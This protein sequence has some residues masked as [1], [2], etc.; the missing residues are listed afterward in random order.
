MKQKYLRI[1]YLVLFTLTVINLIYYAL[2]FYIPDNYFEISSNSN[3]INFFTYFISSVLALFSFFIGPWIIF[4]FIAM[5]LQTF[6][7][8]KLKDWQFFG[9][10]YIYLF[11][12][13]ALSHLMFPSLVGDGLENFI[14]V[15]APKWSIFILTLGFGYLV[16]NLTFNQDLPVLIKKIKDGY[17]TYQ[18]NAFIFLNWCREKYRYLKP[19]IFK[20]NTFRRNIA[21]KMVDYLRASQEKPVTINNQRPISPQTMVN[22]PIMP[23]PTTVKAEIQNSES[24]PQ[25]SNIKTVMTTENEEVMEESFDTNDISADE[26]QK[27]LERSQNIQVQ[28]EDFSTENLLSAISTKDQQKAVT[29]PD[30]VYFYS[31]IKAIEKKLAEFRIEAKVINISKGPVVDTFELEL[32]E[33]VKVSKIRDYSEDISLALSGIPIRMVH[34]MEGRSTIGIEV[35][36]SPR[37]L[38]FL[39]EVLQENIYT[40]SK[41][42]LPIAMG[43][44]SFGE[45]VVVDLEGM[46]HLLVAGTTGSGKSV[47][48]NTLLVSLV[49]KRSPKNLRLILIDPKQLELAHFQE[50]PHL[51][52]PIITDAAHALNALLWCVQEMERRYSIL[53]DFGVKNIEGYNIKLKNAELSQLAKINKYFEDEDSAGYELPYIVIIFD[54]YADFILSKYGKDIETN[55]SRLAAK[56]RASGMHIVLGTQRPSTQVVTGVIKSNFPTRISFKVSS[57][58]DS[59]VILDQMGAEKLLGKGDMLYRRGV[60]LKRYHSAFINEQEIEKLMHQFAKMPPQFNSKA[61]EFLENGPEEEELGG[62]ILENQDFNGGDELM[63]RAIQLVMEKRTASASMFQRHFNIGYPRAGKL[64]DDMERRGIIGPQQG[65]K[66]RKVLGISDS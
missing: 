25:E 63:E 6:K 58:I 62:G 66:P 17:K 7:K 64:I 36:R 33:G 5:T 10:P 19:Y 23:T 45:P 59:R 14:T 32:G 24:E 47:F 28:E 61:V 11:F 8:Q 21:A 27:T 2:A 30:D 37:E 9:S 54:E 16:Y 38:I 48:L 55:I 50:L 15:F 49:V 40:Q 60:D 65:S 12:F 3:Q 46:P 51:L 35:P 20:M 18:R 57:Q 22:K 29:S 42:H 39:D 52:L 53:K 31:I 41:F 4:P 1:H 26:L 13:L 56:A 44:N 34:P 43:K